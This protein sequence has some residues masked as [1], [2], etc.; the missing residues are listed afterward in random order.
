MD[1]TDSTGC[2]TS[3]TNASEGPS[4]AVWASGVGERASLGLTL[5]TVAVDPSTALASIVLPELASVFRPGEVRAIE[6]CVA[7]HQGDEWEPAQDVLELTVTAGPKSETFGT[8]VWQSVVMAGWT[9]AQVRNLLRDDLVDFVAE[10][11][12]GWG[13]RRG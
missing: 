6:I 3:P 5:H 4:A 1:V 12:F 13:E 10:S 2:C 11:S 8:P 7:T 9:A